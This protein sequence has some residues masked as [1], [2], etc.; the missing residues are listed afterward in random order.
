MQLKMILYIFKN[1]YDHDYTFKPN[2]E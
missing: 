2:S 1:Q